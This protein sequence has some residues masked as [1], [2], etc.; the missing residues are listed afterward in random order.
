MHPVKVTRNK[1]G[2]AAG[3]GKPERGCAGILYKT[4]REA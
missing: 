1:E 2:E 3:E 4:K